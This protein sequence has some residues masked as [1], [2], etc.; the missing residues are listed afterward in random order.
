LWVKRGAPPPPLAECTPKITDFGL[1]KRV[2]AG[3]GLTQT[4]AI[5]GTPGYMAPEQ[6][7]AKKDVGP[8]A[9]VYALGAILY[10]MLTGRPP[11]RAPTQLD[12]VLQVLSSEPVPPARLQ[13][14]CPRDLETICLECLHKDP[15]RRY[16]SALALAEDLERFLTDRPVLARRAGTPERLR[17]WARRNPVVA[18]M[19]AA[20]ALLLLLLTSGSLL[21][22]LWLNEARKTAE[23]NRRTAEDAERLRTEQLATSYLEQARARRYSRQVG[24]R[25]QSL[26]A[27]TEATRIIRGM[28]LDPERRAERLRELRDEAIASLALVDLRPGRRLADVFINTHGTGFQQAVV[29]APKW[30]VYARAETDGPVSVRRLADDGEI[31]RLPGA[32]PTAYILAFSLDGRYLLAKYYRL[33]K[34]IEYIVWDWRAGRK[35]VRQSCAPNISPTIDFAFTPD[36]RHVL[37]GCRPDALLVRYDLATGD[38]AGLLDAGAPGPWAIALHADGR[39]LATASG[40]EVTIRDARTGAPV[41]A[42]WTLPGQV[43]S[44]AWQRGGNLLAAGSGP[45]IYLFD[46]ATRRERGTLEGQEAHVV[47]LAFNRAGTLLASYGWDNT[48][49]L[50]DPAGGKELLHVPGEFMQFSPDGR[51]L[52]YVKGK[53]LG[54]WEL[55]EEDVCR[56]LIHAGW[57]NRVQFHPDGRILA[58]GAEDDAY[59]WDARTGKQLARLRLGPTP[60]VLFHPSG[61]LVTSSRTFGLS[62]WPLRPGAEGGRLR[63]GPPAAVPTPAGAHADT[64]CMDAAGERLALAT[65][66][67][68]AVV[69][70]LKGGAEPLVLTGHPR[71]RYIDLSPDGRWLAASTFKGADVKVWD[72]AARDPRK[73]AATFPTGERAAALFSLDGRWFVV[74][75][76]VRRVRYFYRVG[77]WELAR[78]EPFD[79]GDEGVAFTADG[80]VMA[81][82]AQG[83]REVRLLDPATGRSWATLPSLQGRHLY[84]LSFNRDG[85][86]LAAAGDRFLQLWDLRALRAHLDEMG[87]DW[88]AGPYP[89]TSEVEAEGPL[90]VTVEGAPGAGPPPPV[91]VLPPARRPA[92]AEEIAAWVQQL[93]DIDARRR[94]AAADALAAVGP[95]AVKALSAA[96]GGPEGERRKQALIVL[97]RIAVAEAL[98][99]TRVRLRLKDVTPA[100]A[101]RALAEQ[102]GLPLSCT[103][104]PGQRISLDL[105]D[106]TVWQALDRICD[107]AD[108]GVYVNPAKIWA[109]PATAESQ[110]VRAPAGPFRLEV[111]GADYR[112]SIHARGNTLGAAEVLSLYVRLF[113]EPRIPLLSVRQ[114]RLT[115]ARGADGQSLLA[116][117]PPALVDVAVNPSAFMTGLG[118]SLKPMAGRPDKLTVVE[119]VLP[120][121]VMVRRQELAA[122]P[123]LARAEGHTFRGEQGHRVTLTSVR[124]SGNQWTLEC[125]I[126]G[127]PG[128]R[129]DANHYG[130]EMIDARGRLARFNPRLQAEAALPPL[131]EN[132]LWL[133]PAPP[134]LPWPALALHAAGPNRVEWRGT[135]QQTTAVPFESPVRLH[136]YRF[137]RLRTEVPFVLRDVPLP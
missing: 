42:P 137:D 45:R 84:R 64:A 89:P 72:L 63:L 35:V 43:W 22:A 104:P 4:G 74:D 110:T 88:P 26:E 75:E 100:E 93:G 33:E 60:A 54:I 109:S 94:T 28:D 136:F 67:Q 112:R 78:Q 44:L 130:L 98:A 132:L 73:P 123:D 11:F 105:D 81:A 120:V 49:R 36:G 2:E 86:R 126:S 13:P 3:P 57:V 27:L 101:L 59:L 118:I 47:K 87:L 39:R 127:P 15:E 29:F 38:E 10:E 115:E 76:P 23:D 55:A 135:L 62:R 65:P 56:L 129:Y 25:F 7:E 19:T 71:L 48:T 121:E 79:P 8:P 24:Q 107:A 103:A 31:I 131:A 91:V 18:G 51:R 117:A 12:T 133:A 92:R 122:V 97:D 124:R 125:R 77:T 95:P 30:D 80:R 58:A 20:V 9:D 21:A 14:G 70:D 68:Q 32:G 114:P 119:G 85:S 106:V 41:G 116:P 66:Q 128:F 37:L 17:R 82:T 61:D 52:S 16:P 34:P 90:A 53:E 102:C 99:P 96:A 83:G 113:K 111:V 69:V 46:A 108:L 1:A 5:L 6:A 50:W 134:A 40:R